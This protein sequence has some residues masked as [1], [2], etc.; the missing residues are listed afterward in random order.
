MTGKVICLR[1]LL[2]EGNYVKKTGS[3]TIK[4][5][6]RVD[7]VDAVVR[8]NTAYQGSA[9]VL[10]YQKS[11]VST[12]SIAHSRFQSNTNK[13]LGCVTIRKSSFPALLSLF[14]S[15]SSFENNTAEEV[16]SAI[17]LLDFVPL[18]NRSYIENC[19]FVNNSNWEHG[20]ALSLSYSDGPLE[21]RN[22][23]FEGNN[24][25]YGA[26]VYMRNG[27]ASDATLLVL[28]QCVFRNNTGENVVNLDGNS[29][30]HS[31]RL[32][33]EHNLCSCFLIIAGELYDQG[34]IY[35][36]NTGPRGSSVQ[37]ISK[38]TVVI[39]DCMLIENQA[40]YGGALFISSGSSVTIANCTA[41]NNT[42]DV[43]GGVAY[44]DQFST[45]TLTHTVLVGN[46]ASEKGSAVY[47]I[48]GQVVVTDSSLM[49]NYAKEYGTICGADAEIK[50]IN[51]TIM[52]NT[53]G[54]SSP[55]IIGS[56]LAIQADHCHFLS[57][58]AATGA[59]FLLDQSQLL[60]RS[61]V[62]TQCVALLS[63]GC[64]SATFSTVTLLDSN[65]TQTVAPAGAAIN[66]DQQSNLTLISVSVFHTTSYALLGAVM[67][68]GGL[69]TILNSS[70]GFN[71][72][73]A[74]YAQYGMLIINGTSFQRATGS[75]GSAVNLLFSVTVIENSLF[76]ENSAVQGGAIYVL[77]QGQEIIIRNSRFEGN[78]ATS[79]GGFYSESACPLLENNT[80][81]GNQAVRIPEIAASGSGGAVVLSSFLGTGC[82]N[83]LRGSRFK[84][85]FASIRG[86]AVVW[87]YTPPQFSANVFVNNTALY[88]SD[89]AS[90]AV[91]LRAI[92]PEGLI[93]PYL[94]ESTQIPLALV[95]DNLGS[96][97]LFDGLIRLGFF[98]HQ[99][100]LVTID[101]SSGVE[102]TVPVDSNLTVFGSIKA[103]ASYGMVTF[104]QFTLTAAPGTSQ[105]IKISAPGI[106]KQAL[107]SPFDDAIIE[108]T[109]L[110]QFS[111]REC[112]MGEYQQGNLC[113]E[114]KAGTY[115]FHPTERCA[116]CPEGAICY[117]NY[118]M[119]P[120]PG[121]WRAD[122][123]SAVFFPCEN[124]DA[125]LGS[126]SANLSLQGLC[127][128]GY[129]G[130]VCASC[131]ENYSIT[132]KDVCA[133]CPSFAAN[134]MLTAIVV[135]VALVFLVLAVTIAIRSA[136]R[137]N[138]EL[139]VYVKILMNYT[140]MMIIAASLNMHWPDY[141][142]TFLNAQIMVGNAAEQ[143]FSVDCLLQRISSEKLL[144][145]KI[146][147]ISILPVALL[148]LAVLTWLLIALCTSVTLLKEKLVATLVMVLFLLHTTI[149]KTTF[150]IFPCKEL[151]RGE[152]WLEKD[153][154]QRCWDFAHIR[155]I[156]TVALPSIV[157]W[158]VG[159]P[160]VCLL[161]I[162]RRRIAL[163]SPKVQMQY[164]FLYK[165]YQ[166]E[167]YFWEFVILYR[168]I[169]LVVTLV[170]LASVSAAIQAQTILFILI[171]SIASQIYIRPF[172]I[173]IMNVLETKSILASLVTVYCGL[174]YESDALGNS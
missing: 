113:D 32:L 11:T 103:V 1:G 118:T 120:K 169:A 9:G 37:V 29:R 147:V 164:S 10:I 153:L 13:D 20:A 57:Q 60:V 16:G 167:H 53:V 99:N 101:S 46:V 77:G 34:S 48:Y 172:N 150:S 135:L 23:L 72:G 149:T 122:I 5:A 27:K 145:V 82:L 76:R 130:N 67:V 133:E 171:L 43:V 52:N 14:V 114:C 35:R 28:I 59:M 45:L 166:R 93:K 63:G 161:Y 100:Q 105:Y 104:S 81:I 109:M 159:L 112:L 144:F 56:S 68:N 163:H 88:G 155:F 2:A 156:E 138:S 44:V 165:G 18:C 173:A 75:T 71:T 24:A 111:F 85:N 97:H 22:S 127:G 106:R 102:I 70:F 6:E 146:A 94:N 26:A 116:A 136:S 64:I 139:A 21:V 91:K 47:V 51:C 124:S 128:S 40:N 110:V 39:Q 62:F 74:V 19:T 126:P 84:E 168:K 78:I 31:T 121:Y 158:V 87:M 42:A 12:V 143:I 38:S 83:V 54:G 131:Q 8:N 69:T 89:I 160:M 129:K 33:F 86:G 65:M 125:C 90:Y 108:D 98:D 92:T 148:L 17:S 80:F 152:Q 134:F 41:A 140:Q 107:V 49:R 119:V 58:N 162:H 30:I 142:A 15:N 25:R 55:G 61:S 36:G 132:G 73:L 4:D 123:Y 157:V 66:L 141:T 154:D 115:S 170:F 95:V 151:K 7:I 117:G 174:Y 50:L 137:P 96:G 79:G 3:V